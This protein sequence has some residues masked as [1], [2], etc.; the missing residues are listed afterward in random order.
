[1]SKGNAPAKGCAELSAASIHS[2]RMGGVVSKGE[3]PVWAC[4]LIFVSGSD[5][6]YGIRYIYLDLQGDIKSIQVPICPFGT[7]GH[8]GKL[9][10]L[11]RQ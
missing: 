2:W 10:E 8:S 11:F 4:I 9:V 1:M 3:H 6:E 5:S 7:G